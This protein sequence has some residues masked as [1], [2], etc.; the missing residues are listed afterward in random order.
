MLGR[1]N[2]SYCSFNTIKKISNT[3][4][5]YIGEAISSP[6]AEF[7]NLLQFTRRQNWKIKFIESKLTFL[8][9]INIASVK[10]SEDA[11]YLI[12]LIN[13]KTHLNHI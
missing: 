5:N 9:N 7:K 1:T 12:T 8:N 10:V 13:G 3:L 11:D 2:S 6:V 4:E